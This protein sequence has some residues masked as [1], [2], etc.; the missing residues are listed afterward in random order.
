[1]DSPILATL[2]IYG[3]A[4]VISAFVAVMIKVIYWSVSFTQREKKK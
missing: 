2:I 1:M 3:L 4:A